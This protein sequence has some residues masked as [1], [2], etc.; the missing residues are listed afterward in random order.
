ML[1]LSNLG[2]IANWTVKNFQVSII[3]Y[4][5]SMVS[6]KPLKGQLHLNLKKKKTR[7]KM[8]QTNSEHSKSVG[9][10]MRPN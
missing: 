6:Y 4:Y 8:K 2:N 5:V 3:V 9:L 1:K 10:G 7:N